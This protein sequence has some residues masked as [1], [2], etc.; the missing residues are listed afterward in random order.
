MPTL[1]LAQVVVV[2]GRM[3]PSQRAGRE[4]PFTV[5]ISTTLRPWASLPT[6]INRQ[7]RQVVDLT[8]AGRMAGPASSPGAAH[9]RLKKPRKVAEPVVF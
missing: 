9:V 8:P 6:T 2:E 7:V 4:V 5:E 1:A 3:L